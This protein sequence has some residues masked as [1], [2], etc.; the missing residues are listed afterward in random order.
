MPYMSF[1]LLKKWITELLF[2]IV[3]YYKMTTMELSETIFR[4]SNKLVIWMDDVEIP[5]QWLSDFHNFLIQKETSICTAGNQTPYL[6][7]E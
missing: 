6:K 4:G 3:N 1:L 7:E 5:F 2:F